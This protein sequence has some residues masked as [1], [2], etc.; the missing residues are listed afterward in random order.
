M[1]TFILV[2]L[3]LLLLFFFADA[4]K[5]TPPV[6][7]RKQLLSDRELT[8]YRIIQKIAEEKGLQVLIKE[9]LSHLVTES[10]SSKHREFTKQ[11][12]DAAARTIDFIIVDR[13]LEIRLLIVLS[14]FEKDEKAYAAQLGFLSLIRKHTNYQVVCVSDSADDIEMI[15][16]KL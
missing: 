6:Y 10:S 12:K 2:L 9:P 7:D 5:V 1:G 11:F 4:M 14:E 15:R 3:A 13:N 16:K 8:H